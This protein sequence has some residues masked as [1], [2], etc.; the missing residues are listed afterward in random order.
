MKINNFRG[1]LTDSSAIKEPLKL[2]PLVSTCLEKT[3]KRVDVTPYC[4]IA[5]KNSSLCDVTLIARLTTKN[6]LCQ[7]LLRLQPLRIL[8]A[9]KHCEVAY[10][11]R[12]PDPFDAQVALSI[13]WTLQKKEISTCAPQKSLVL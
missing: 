4:R 10:K 11:S 6:S 1:E 7:S 2:T 3:N 5:P 13:I 9:S 8:E 12:F